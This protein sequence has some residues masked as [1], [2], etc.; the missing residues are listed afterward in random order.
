MKHYELVEMYEVWA[1][2]LQSPR[3][4]KL[5]CVKVATTFDSE[6][7]AGCVLPENGSTATLSSFNSKSSLLILINCA[8]QLTLWLNRG[9]VL[10]ELVIERNKGYNFIQVSSEGYSLQMKT[11]YSWESMVLVWLV[12]LLI[13]NMAREISVKKFYNFGAKSEEIL[14]LRSKI[15]MT[16]SIGMEPTEPLFDKFFK[17]EEVEFLGVWD[18]G[19]WDTN[20]GQT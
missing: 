14:Q 1:L 4:L 12:T 10:K 13:S 19:E 17:M 2:E 9:K 16:F 7:N 3:K 5:A 15:S 20:L 18:P 11:G 6:E 8:N